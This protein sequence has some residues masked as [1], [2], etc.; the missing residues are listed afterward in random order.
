[1]SI[2]KEIHLEDEICADLAAAGWLYDADD[3]ARY[4][5]T[6]A[7]FVDDVVAWIKASQPKAWDAIE[8]SHGATAP[9]VRGRT[10]AQGPGQPGHA[11]GAAPRLRDD[12]PE[13]P[14]RHVPVQAG[15][16]DERRPAGPLRR[17]PPARGAPGALLRPPREQHRPGAVRQRHPGG[18]RRAQE[19]LH[20]ER[21]GRDLP[22]QDRPRA[23]VQA[24][25]RR[26]SRC[27]PSPAAR[28]CT[29][30]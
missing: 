6:L 25:E 16:G 4:D 1:M 12:R 17:Q 9:K 30:P 7:L 3:A 21:A 26:P 20:A 19:P 28:W 8:K 18:H 13:A 24:Q 27:W 29:S 15:A 11:G 22:V 23:A 14:D 5:R 10:P 2:H